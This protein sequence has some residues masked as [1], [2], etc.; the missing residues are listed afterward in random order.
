M[1]APSHSSTPARPIPFM[2]R[3]AVGFAAVSVAAF[4][5]WAFGGRWFSGHGGEGAM[6]ATI[7]VAFVLLTG[8]L[9]HPL[10][11]GDRRLGRFYSI[12]AP[13]FV[14]YAVVWSVFW[15]WLKAGLGEWLGAFLGSGIFV[16]LT[17]WRLG[18]WQGFALAAIVFFALHTAGYF[19]GG[20]SM[21]LLMAAAR[22]KPTPFLDAA[23]LVL[24][25]KLS[26]GL[27]YG[28]GFG[29]G[30]GYVFAALQPPATNT[31]A[32]SGVLPS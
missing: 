17:A 27:F 29:A 13:A 21:D 23:T 24:L 30:L 25:A 15:F 2:L 12:F 22:Q 20:R 3:G 18:R 7:A 5:I 14:A 9:L 31:S 10:V 28:L 16:A 26:W 8:L 6:Y 19:A 32:G 4:A 11:P 1:S